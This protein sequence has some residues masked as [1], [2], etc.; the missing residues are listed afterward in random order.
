LGRFFPFGIGSRGVPDSGLRLYAGFLEESLIWIKR[1]F[2]LQTS[3]SMSL[4]KNPDER[5]IESTIK[6]ME[7]EPGVIRLQYRPGEMIFHP[8]NEPGGT[9]WV[10]AGQIKLEAID[11][12]GKTHFL[13]VMSESKVLGLGACLLNR[14][15]AYQAKTLGDVSV[16]WLDSKSTRKFM[17]DH[18]EVAEPL[19]RQLCEELELLEGRLRSAY[20]LDATERVYET[21]LYLK[22]C[23]PCRNWSRGEIAEWAGTT[24][25]TVARAIA[26]LREQ[27]RILTE[28]R[29]ILLLRKK[30]LN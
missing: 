22:K 5:L 24:P 14:P 9:Y 16:I 2:F 18:P 17:V 7:K 23:D 29:R 6:K 28:G 26:E 21:I 11:P 10:R 8:G 3:R 20:S 13:H 4:E 12:G 15:H 19:M 25:E 30:F 27:A 1:A